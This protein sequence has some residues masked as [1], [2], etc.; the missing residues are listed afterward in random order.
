MLQVG[1]MIHIKD[2]QLL[3]KEWQRMKEEDPNIHCDHSS[4]LLEYAD[5]IGKT[6]DCICA[7]CGT[8]FSAK[9][10]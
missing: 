9:E 4:L 7:K 2:A 5:G 1:N 6:G 8:A 3:F 10:A